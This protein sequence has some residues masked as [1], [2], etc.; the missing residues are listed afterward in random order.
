MCRHLTTKGQKTLRQQRTECHGEIDKS[1]IIAEEF[2]T[3]LSEM[4]RSYRQ[5]ISKDIRELNNIISQRD[6][7]DII[8]SLNNSRI[9][10]YIIL[11]S[12]GTY[13]KLDPILAIKTNLKE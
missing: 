12:H 7:T 5:K 11:G 10:I 13:N 4:G 2:N 8:L 1:I 6:I 9:Y 3:P